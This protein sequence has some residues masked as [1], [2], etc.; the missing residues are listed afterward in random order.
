MRKR[1][2]GVLFGV[3]AILF[4]GVF[5]AGSVKAGWVFTKDP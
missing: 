2:V 1:G 5:L 4:L 3:I